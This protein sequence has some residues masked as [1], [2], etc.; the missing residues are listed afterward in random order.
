MSSLPTQASRTAG[1]GAIALFPGAFQ[2]PHGAHLAAV[3]YL[4]QRPDVDRVVIII[5]NRCRGIPGTN[6]SLDAQVSARIWQV[7]LDGADDVT[8]EIAPHTAVDHALGYLDF[9]RPGER[10][11]Y[12]IGEQDMGDGDPRFDTLTEQARQRGVDAQVVAAPTAGI[13]VRATG[14]RQALARGDDGRPEFMAHLPTELDDVRRARIWQLCREGLRPVS[15]LAAA[16]L[17][18]L[19]GEA[20]MGDTTLPRCLDPTR[21]DPVFRVV[22]SDGARWL[23]RYAGDAEGADGGADHGMARKPRRALKVERR[24]LALLR[25]HRGFGL[26]LPRER[27]FDRRRGVLVMDELLPDGQTLAARL[28]AGTPVADPLARV[29]RFLAHCHALRPDALRN[30]EAEDRAHW[31][32]YLEARGLAS[33]GPPAERPCLVWLHAVAGAVRIDGYRVGVVDFEHAGSWGDPAFDLGALVGDCLVH[34]GGQ[35]DLAPLL[36]AYRAVA[37]DGDATLPGRAAAWAAA[38]LARMGPDVSGRAAALAQLSSRAP[39][40]WSALIRETTNGR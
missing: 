32:A 39:R 30:S 4:R 13:P 16:R 1:R 22:K 9:A 24:A 26:L 28:A 29:G 10:L 18:P 15:T 14:L 12:C 11:L 40:D 38:C 34:S 8:I 36:L 17:S 7:Y 27:H 6:L 3:S 33:G 37:G 2:P 25:G 35:A 31:A 21:I 23:V 20:G 5:S 19:L